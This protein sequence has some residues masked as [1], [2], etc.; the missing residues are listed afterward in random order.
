MP[1]GTDW[2]LRLSSDLYRSVECKVKFPLTRWGN[3]T[4]DIGG[5]GSQDNENMYL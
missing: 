5:K 4:N 2:A 1:S 3:Q